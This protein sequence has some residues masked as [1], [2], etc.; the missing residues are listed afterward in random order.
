MN[1]RLDKRT[2]NDARYGG[3][4]GS[5]EPAPIV[6]RKKRRQAAGFGFG[7]QRGAGFALGAPGAIAMVLS[8][9]Y[10]GHSALT[11]HV[12]YQEVSY[13]AFTLAF[14][15][16]SWLA[17]LLG[18]FLGVEGNPFLNSIVDLIAVVASL[19][20][21]FFAGAGAAAVCLYQAAFSG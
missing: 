14:S 4:Y 2:Y 15:D 1:L 9:L 12:P 21:A 18:T 17:S 6:T 8:M 11:M 16:I 19:I 7:I 13:T 10:G 3:H 5:D 20:F